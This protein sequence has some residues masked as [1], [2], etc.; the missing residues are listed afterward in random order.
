MNVCIIGSGLTS[1]TLAKNLVNKKINVHIYEK[2]INKKLSPNRTIGISKVNLDFF[3]NKIHLLP[4]KIKWEIKKIEIYSKDLKKNKILNFENN[5][6]ILFYMI[7]ND[8][9]YDFLKKKLLKNKFYK[10]KQIENDNFYEKLLK[11]NNY[12]LIINCDQNNDISKKYFI[13]KIHKDYKNLAFITILKH[14]KI[15]NNSAIQI[16]TE[17]GPIAFLPISN[18][19]TSVVY[20]IDVKNK[21]FTDS[22]IIN[23][24]K[25]YNFKYKIKKISK[26]SSFELKSSN[27]RSYYHKNILGFGD[28]LHRVHPF[29]G[30]GFNII[31]RDIQKLSEII[32]K[33]IN[34]GLQLDSLVLSEFEKKTK[35]RNF[36][37]SNGLDF[38]YEFFSLNKKNYSDKPY[39]I[40][41]FLGNNKSF[42]SS[43]I[44]IADRGLDI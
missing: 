28:L 31:L 15:S 9:L 14:Q 32:Q 23:L 34:L 4:K 29:A 43:V 24:I 2:K 8:D 42:M 17:L 27:L 39:K 37:F 22:E 11:K 20:S 16:F 25:T 40:L 3:E 41:K 44:K 6:K 38:I 18:T 21:K 33:K 1:L 5:K 12:D 36:I 35:N 7:R 13:K 19:E 30:Q 26:L 10:K